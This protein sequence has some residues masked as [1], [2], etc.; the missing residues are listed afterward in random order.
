M[1]TK[2]YHTVDQI[3]ERILT[4]YAEKYPT[5]AKLQDAVR[6]KTRRILFDLKDHAH[7]A[8]LLEHDKLHRVDPHHL[9][10]ADIRIEANSHDLL[11]LFNKELAPMQAF[12]SKRIKVH[13]SF[14][15]LLL[16]KSF[17]G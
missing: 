5:N 3:Y 4:A 10:K 17:L 13:A 7:A 6:G 11:A 15:D 16:A 2:K 1:T 12:L 8:F 14:S 9:G